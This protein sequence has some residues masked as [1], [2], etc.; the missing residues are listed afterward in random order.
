MLLFVE[1]KQ[2]QAQEKEI[3]FLMCQLTK[4]KKEMQMMKNHR[5]GENEETIDNDTVIL[6]D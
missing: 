1:V 2:K 6:F 4:A 3:V 5:R